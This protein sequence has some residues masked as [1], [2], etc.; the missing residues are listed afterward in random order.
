M[1]NLTPAKREALERLSDENGIIGALA[2]DQRGS[3]KKMLQQESTND[4]GDDT[5]VSFKELISEELTPY[6]TSILLDPEYGLPAAQKRDKSAGLLL[7]YEKTG[8][9]ATQPGRMPD[10]LDDWSV[11]RIKAQGADAVKFLL[12]YDVDEDT[13]I[14]EKKHIF[15]E[16][17]GSECQAEDILFFLELVSYD[18]HNDDVKGREYAKVKPHKVNDMMKEFSKSQYKV[19]VLKVEVPVNMSYVEG[20]SEETPVYST[21]E[22][23]RYFK[24]Q[25]EATD[26]PFIFL[27]AGVSASLFQETLRFAKEAGSS[28]NGV[29]CGRATWKDSVAIFGRD[30][31][32]AGKQW[33]QLE[34]R[35]NVEALNEVLKQT[36]TSWKQA[37]ILA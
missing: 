15:V 16:R 1:L 19:D 6:A 28:F 27:S 13:S 35:K 4:Q 20:F 8:Y 26:L 24:E 33:L 23:Q 37:E 34:G 10:I 32:V 29:L 11:Q 5:I 30:G 22:A 14:N 18:A 3:L 7:A 25:S 36:A 9:D 12:Y 17:L 2:I 31:E 21:E